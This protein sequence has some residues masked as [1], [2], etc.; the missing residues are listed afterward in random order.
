MSR[1]DF[2]L[3]LVVSAG[4]FFVGVVWAPAFSSTNDLKKPLEYTSYIA[5]ILACAVAIYTLSSWRTQFRHS[6]KYNAIKSL[7]DAALGMQ[8]VRSY[9]FAMQTE[10][11]QRYATN[12]V[13]VEV[14]K[15]AVEAERE[16]CTEALRSYHKAWITASALLSDSEQADYPGIYSEVFDTVYQYPL[17]MACLYADCT[18]NEFIWRAREVIAQHAKLNSDMIFWLRKKLRQLA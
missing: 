13:P 16:L 1:N 11:L 12:G 17:Q 14:L 5:T 9:L 15:R 18:M 10:F 7:T 8:V 6:E 3:L 4:L 2:F